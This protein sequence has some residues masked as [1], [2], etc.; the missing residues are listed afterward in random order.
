MPRPVPSEYAAI[1]TALETGPKTLRQLVEAIG[2]KYQKI[3][4]TV[5]LLRRDGKIEKLAPVDNGFDRV[6]G[7]P[8]ARYRLIRL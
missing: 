1:L 7:R 3:K 6:P 2:A 5:S 8:P 4:D